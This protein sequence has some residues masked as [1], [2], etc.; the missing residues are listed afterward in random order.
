VVVPITISLFPAN[1]YVIVNRVSFLGNASFIAE[2]EKIIGRRR[3]ALPRGRPK[4][5]VEENEKK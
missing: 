4:K 2:L 3:R 5:M 1:D